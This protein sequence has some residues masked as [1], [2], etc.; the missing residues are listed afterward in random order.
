MRTFIFRVVLIALIV[1][2]TGCSPAA[3][4]IPVSATPSDTATPAP[5][6]ATFTPS[7]S[8]TPIATADFT[9]ADFLGTWFRS[10]P[11]RGNLYMIFK[12]D[13][14]YIASHGTPDGVVHS[15]KFKLDGRVLT[16][17]NG[18]NCSPLG[19]TVGMYILQM[20]G[21]GKFL[22]FATLDDK[23]PDRPS[24]LKSVRWNKIVAP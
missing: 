8:P 19:N 21:G 2:V 15:G 10:D 13:G 6:T 11:D 20:G 9:L 16:F 1:A 14:G 18:W 22:Y 23:C 24:A 3:T 12:E 7:I 4:E 17:E 5:P